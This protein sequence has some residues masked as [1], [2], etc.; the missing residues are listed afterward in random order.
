MKKTCEVFENRN[1]DVVPLQ[2]QKGQKPRFR[3]AVT[4]VC[5][6]MPYRSIARLTIIPTATNNSSNGDQ[7]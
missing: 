7:L 6:K 1:G 3:R 2:R 5:L 4:E